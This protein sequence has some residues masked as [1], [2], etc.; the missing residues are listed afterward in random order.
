MIGL[1]TLY[2]IDKRLRQIRSEK[3]MLPFGGMSIVLMGDFAQLPPMGD[4][5]MFTSKSDLSHYQ[6]I[7]KA[8]F[9]MFDMNMLTIQII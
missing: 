9:D 3:S 7:G 2:I 8:L 1:Y 5:P 4:L 6:Y